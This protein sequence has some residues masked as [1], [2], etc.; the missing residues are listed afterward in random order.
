M[1]E[2][3]HNKYK[4][5]E[6]RLAVKMSLECWRKLV[7]LSKL[8]DVDCSTCIRGLIEDAVKDVKLD[9]NDL[10]IISRRMLKNLGKQLGD[11][12]EGNND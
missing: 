6:T 4:A 8:K 11:T 7:K 3:R 9:L 2:T 10:E 5:S 1:K 12:D